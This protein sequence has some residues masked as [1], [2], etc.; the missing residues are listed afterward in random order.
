LEGP[1]INKEKKGAHVLECIT[2]MSGGIDDVTA[3]YGSLENVSILTL[4]PELPG[5]LDVIS[6]LSRLG[7]V[8]SLG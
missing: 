8:T 3:I 4:A 2:T 6:S 7:I 5:A 1:F